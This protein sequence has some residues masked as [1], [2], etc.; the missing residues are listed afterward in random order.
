VEGLDVAY[1]IQENLEHFAEPTVWDQGIFQPSKAT[2]DSLIK[3]LPSVDFGIF[4]FSP[5]DV[6]IV[7]GSEHKGVRDNVIFELGLFI[8]SL[9]QERTVIV[10]PRGTDDF[11]FPSDLAGITPASYA[12]DRQDHN[13]T[14]ALGPACNKIR[15]LLQQLG[16]L[17]LRERHLHPVD[18]SPS[19]P[20]D[21][22]KARRAEV[23]KELHTFTG[24]CKGV[25]GDAEAK[26]SFEVGE[27]RL[28]RWKNR[29]MRFIDANISFDDA[30]AFA[31]IHT[32]LAAAVPLEHLASSGAGHV[33]F[34]EALAAEIEADA[35][36]FLTGASQPSGKSLPAVNS[37]TYKG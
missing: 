1:A 8:G 22:S 33:T 31:S 30:R 11:H 24:E 7:R 23:A 2:V 13:L 25:L 10:T 28:K 9:G 16:P 6:T 27:E 17:N 35:H 12:V 37:F 3:C 26:K 4:V 19:P 34:L 21:P 15:R 29:V 20:T 36:F 5:D 32:S 18:P 14:A